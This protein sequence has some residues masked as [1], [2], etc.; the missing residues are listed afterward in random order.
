VGA[1][2]GGGCS[3]EGRLPC[4]MVLA[5]PRTQNDLA[6]CCGAYRSQERHTTGCTVAPTR[7]VVSGAVHLGA[8][9]ATRQHSCSAEALASEKACTWPALRQQRENCCQQR[10]LLGVCVGL[11]CMICTGCTPYSAA[12]SLTV[13]APRTASRTAFA[14]N[15]PLCCRCFVIVLYSLS[16]LCS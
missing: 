9:A 8:A 12:I 4:S 15:A 14:L 11:L 16:T 3:W 5:L 7:E 1:A 10:P 2:P 13:R 6:P